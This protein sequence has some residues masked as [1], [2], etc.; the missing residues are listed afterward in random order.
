M[1]RCPGWDVAAAREHA[2][3]GM[4]LDCL[5]YRMQVLS[6]TAPTNPNPKN[7]DGP[8][9]F[10]MVLES[11]KRTYEQRL[12]LVLPNPPTPNPAAEQN[13]ETPCHLNG[14]H[15]PAMTLMDKLHCPMN[16]QNL[17]SYFE[18]LQ[19]ENGDVVNGAGPS[20][21]PAQEASAIPLYHDLWATMTMSWTDD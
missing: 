3:L 11:I 7:P 4:F 9:I 1:P 8:F 14:F 21:R 20:A 18:P 13:G 17:M 19:F 6:S 10:R 12:S 5:C 2:P 15:T 16:D